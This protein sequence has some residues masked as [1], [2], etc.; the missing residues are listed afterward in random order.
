MTEP[1]TQP[2]ST[3]YMNSIQLARLF[4]RLLA[5]IPAPDLF[6]IVEHAVRGPHPMM[7]RQAKDSDEFVKAT[8]DLLVAKADPMFAKM[9]EGRTR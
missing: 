8:A 2:A 1:T 5:R 4:E 9:S 6:D 3:P 7:M